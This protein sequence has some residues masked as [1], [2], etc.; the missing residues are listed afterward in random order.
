MMHHINSK[1]TTSWLTIV[2]IVLAVLVGGCAI[3]PDVLEQL[4]SLV[5][6]LAEISGSSSNTPE[7]LPPSQPEI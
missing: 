3:H 7:P 2:A 1:E 4:D 6:V 5:D